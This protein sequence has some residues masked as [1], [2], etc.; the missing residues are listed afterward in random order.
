MSSGGNSTGQWYSRALGK[1]RKWEESGNISFL[2][3]SLGT[4]LHH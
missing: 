2:I 4:G 3:R 1:M